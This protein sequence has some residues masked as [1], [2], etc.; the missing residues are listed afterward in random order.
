MEAFTER[1]EIYRQMRRIG[2][3]NH[4]IYTFFLEN[5]RTLSFW[6]DKRSWI[7]AKESVPY[8][9]YSLEMREKP[10]RQMVGPPINEDFNM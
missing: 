7:S 4:Q 10:H 5:K 2:S 6:E 9:H 8:G 1:T 3:A